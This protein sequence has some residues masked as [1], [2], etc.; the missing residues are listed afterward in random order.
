M[1]SGY[2]RVILPPVRDRWDTGRIE[3]FSDGVFSIAATL[4]VLE[5][6]V[7]EADF[8]HLWKG[9]AD[10]WPS[11]LSYATSFLTIGGLWLVH[12]AIFRRLR[13]ADFNVTRLNLLLLMAVAFLPFPTKLVAEA[14]DS[15]SSAERAAVLFYGA[16]LL[17]ISVLITV[18]VRYAGSRP[19]LIE[20]EGRDEVVALAAQSSPNLAFYLVVLAL[21]FLAPK[22]AAFGFLAIAVF[23]IM[24]VRG[25]RH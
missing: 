12:H 7:P 14:I 20:E 25:E 2:T 4:L 9:I 6:A 22:V 8:D 10:Q 18:I 13:F 16:T 23:A 15:S 5:I 3:A 17:V 1:E 11:Y 21:A 24:R 19:E